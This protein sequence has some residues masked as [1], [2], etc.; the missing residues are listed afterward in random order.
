MSIALIVAL[1]VGGLLL[2]FVLGKEEKECIPVGA[3]LLLMGAWKLADHLTEG[4]LSG[5][6][7]IWVYR[8]V[9]AVVLVLGVLYVIRIRKDSKE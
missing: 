2:I 7:A 3:F 5:R 1:L 6:W 4:A 8:A 9:L